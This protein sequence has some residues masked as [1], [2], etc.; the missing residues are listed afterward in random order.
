MEPTTDYFELVQTYAPMV[1][2]AH[3]IPGRIRLKLNDTNADIDIRQG[4]AHARRFSDVWQGIPGIRSAKLNL[5]AKSCTVE[6]DVDQIPFGGW[7]DLLSG[8][9]SDDAQKLLGI[10]QKK[11]ETLQCE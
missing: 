11:Y 2:I 9:R 4:I 8:V 6:Y 1:T 3:H 5:L 10:L 7:A